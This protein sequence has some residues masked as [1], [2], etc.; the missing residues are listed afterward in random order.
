MAFHV[1]QKVVCVN[2]NVKDFRG[3]A[4]G[5]AIPKTRC[6][7]LMLVTASRGG[8]S[9]HYVTARHL[10][11]LCPSMRKLEPRIRLNARGKKG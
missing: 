7:V 2:D 4:G 8:R 11:C 9:G 6:G 1:G 10:T 3:K 5:L